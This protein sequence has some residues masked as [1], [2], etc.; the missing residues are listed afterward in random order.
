MAASFWPVGGLKEEG[1]S[2]YGLQPGNHRLVGSGGWWC[3]SPYYQ[4]GAGQVPA[5]V[6]GY[7]SVGLGEFLAVFLN[8]LGDDVFPCAA[9]T[10]FADLG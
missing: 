9:S 2:P 6:H 8:S 1:C 7:A 10:I 4:V 3:V 5:D